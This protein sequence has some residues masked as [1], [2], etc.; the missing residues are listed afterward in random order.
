MKKSP[1]IKFTVNIICCILLVIMPNNLV[2]S[3]TNDGYSQEMFT[4]IFVI[5][6]LAY[7]GALGIIMLS[8]NQF[9]KYFESN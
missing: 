2:D 5:K 7:S 4:W 9:L 1:Y 6:S 8:V 3:I